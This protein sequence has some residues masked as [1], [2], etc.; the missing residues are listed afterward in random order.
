MQSYISEE[1]EEPK[2]CLHIRFK[3][4]SNPYFHWSLTMAE[5]IKELEKW[6]KNYKLWPEQMGEERV[7]QNFIWILAEQREIPEPGFRYF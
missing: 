7:T 5:L 6:N 1:N 4:S 3:D 2:W